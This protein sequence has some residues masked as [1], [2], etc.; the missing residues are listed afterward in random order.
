MVGLFVGWLVG[1]QALDHFISH[2]AGVTITCDRTANL[3]L[4]LTLNGF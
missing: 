3:V 1:L 4:C 2:P